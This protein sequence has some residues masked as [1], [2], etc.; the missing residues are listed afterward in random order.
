MP[1][2]T[3]AERVALEERVAHQE[4]LLAVLDEVVR[5]FAARVEVL[6]R[7]VGELRRAGDEQPVGPA[8][9]VPPHY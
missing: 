4:R 9:E 7:Q 5:E 8:N 3:D 1:V 6:E 2:M